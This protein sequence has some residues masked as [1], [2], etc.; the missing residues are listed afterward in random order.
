[1]AMTLTSLLRFTPPERAFCPVDLFM[2]AGFSADRPAIDPVLRYH[3]EQ[4]LIDR[5]LTIKDVFA[6]SLLD[7]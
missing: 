6:P 4:G 3:H 1:M 7:T 5:R 2:E